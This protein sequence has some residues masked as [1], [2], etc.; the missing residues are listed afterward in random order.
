MAVCVD[1]THGIS[2]GRSPCRGQVTGALVEIKASGA[3][4]PVDLSLSELSTTQMMMLSE[5]TR[6]MLEALTL[7]NIVPRQPRIMTTCVYRQAAVSDQLLRQ[8]HQ[9]AHP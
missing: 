3:R 7:T 2:S 4:A 6:K 9:G 1:V 8:S 5:H